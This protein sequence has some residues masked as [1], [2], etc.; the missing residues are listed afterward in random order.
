MNLQLSEDR[1]RIVQVLNNL[2]ASA[3]RHSP[4]SSPIQV[5]ASWWSTRPP[6]LAD[7][8]VVFISG[9]GLEGSGRGR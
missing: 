1:R 3:A 7:L 2:L 5:S 6:E 9:Y 8:P 4:E